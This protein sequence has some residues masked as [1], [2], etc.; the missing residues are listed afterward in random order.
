MWEKTDDRE[1]GNALNVAIDLGVNFVDTAL[2]FGILPCLLDHLGIESEL[3]R[4][5]VQDI[6]SIPHHHD[7]GLGHGWN[8]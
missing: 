1:S 8:A 5:S 7:V 2:I 6:H 4:S 3:R